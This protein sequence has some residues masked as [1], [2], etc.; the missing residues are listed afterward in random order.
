MLE[1]GKIY[2]YGELKEIIKEAIDKSLGELIEEFENARKE[3]EESGKVEKDET[4]SLLS[5]MAF[6]MQNTMVGGHI[7]NKLFN[8]ED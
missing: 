7:Y 3:A 5:H 6:A 1:E 4:Q 2:T 8:K